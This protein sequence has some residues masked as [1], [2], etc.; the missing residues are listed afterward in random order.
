MKYRRWWI[1]A[2]VL[3]GLVGGY[4]R[5]S[6]HL[7]PRSAIKV[8]RLLSDLPVPAN[9]RVDRFEEQWTQFGGGFAEVRLL[10]PGGKLPAI[11]A[12]ADAK[13]YRTLSMSDPRYARFAGELEGDPEALIRVSGDP[14]HGNFEMAILH[15]GSGRLLV[16]TEVP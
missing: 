6:D 1:G 10:V 9:A 14:S 2:V 7:P 12:A 3:A 5:F 15:P 11:V 4:W 8:A 13:G 16:R